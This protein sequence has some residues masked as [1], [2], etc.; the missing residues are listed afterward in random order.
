MGSMKSPSKHTD[1]LWYRAPQYEILLSGGV[2]ATSYKEHY[3]MYETPEIIA[4]FDAAELL[5]EAFGGN[6]GKG[7]NPGAGL[8]SEHSHV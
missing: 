6:E 8:G 7:P 1:G 5:G 3:R 2:N 4:S